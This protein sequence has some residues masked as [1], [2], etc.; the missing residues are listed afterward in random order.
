MDLINLLTIARTWGPAAALI[1][2]FLWRDAKREDRMSQKNDQL[3]GAIRR[4]VMPLVKKCATVITRNTNAME[5]LEELFQKFFGEKIAE[6]Q[7]AKRPVR[8][9]KRQ[10]S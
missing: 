10:A 2:Y 4:T 3:E 8:R 7:K 6:Q 5:R 9:K 1:V